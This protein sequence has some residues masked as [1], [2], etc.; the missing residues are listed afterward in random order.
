MAMSKTIILISQRSNFN[1]SCHA[2]SLNR[3][4]FP[5]CGKNTSYYRIITGGKGFFYTPAAL[6]LSGSVEISMY[7]S[8]EGI[9]W[10]QQNCWILDMPSSHL[11]TSHCIQRMLLGTFNQVPMPGCSGWG[12]CWGAQWGWTLPTAGCTEFPQKGVTDFQFIYIFYCL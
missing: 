3:E 8:E 9:F 2:A 1:S 12:C 6:L 11:A 10:F 5:K 4:Y 7:H